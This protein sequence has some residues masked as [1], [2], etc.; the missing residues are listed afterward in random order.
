MNYKL[1][2]ALLF[3]A[4]MFADFNTDKAELDAAQKQVDEAHARVNGLRSEIDG[5]HEKASAVSGQYE[6]RETMEHHTRAG[7]AKSA[8]MNKDAHA[9][10]DRALQRRQEIIAKHGK[11]Y[12]VVSHDGKYT[13]EKREMKSEKPAPIR[14]ER[15]TRTSRMLRTTS[16]Y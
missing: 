15:P 5:H 14:M 10:L 13:L 16:T 1:A 4:P 9:E 8:A 12:H 6:Q 7:R 2:L 3:S 11:R